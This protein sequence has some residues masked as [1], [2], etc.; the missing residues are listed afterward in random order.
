MA[1]ENRAGGADGT[2]NI[3]SDQMKVQT[4]ASVKFHYEQ[5]KT[6]TS[7]KS[8]QTAFRHIHISL[9]GGDVG[10]IGY[11]PPYL[12]ICLA[13][14]HT[15]KI[16]DVLQLAVAVII[17]NSMRVIVQA[18]ARKLGGGRVTSAKSS[19]LEC[20]RVLPHASHGNSIPGM[21]STPESVRAWC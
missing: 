14:C 10:G 2:M 1:N 17:E 11:F 3:F 5:S 12:T 19:T 21:T 16:K 6:H 9:S 4:Q 20:L 18:R 7:Q 15:K 8:E 13:S